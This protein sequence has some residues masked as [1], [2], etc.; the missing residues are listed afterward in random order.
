MPTSTDAST[1]KASPE[2]LLPSVSEIVSALERDRQ[3]EIATLH[4]V[5]RQVCAEEL[6]RVKKGLTT[7]PVDVLVARARDLLTTPGASRAQAQRVAL[8]CEDEVPF[9]GLFAE[10]RRS[11]L[12][13]VAALWALAAVSLTVYQLQGTPKSPMRPSAAAG[14]ASRR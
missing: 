7:A 6:L 2:R 13:F 1:T 9:R 3:G 10:D 11:V 14:Q 12:T 4:K 8:P 5:A